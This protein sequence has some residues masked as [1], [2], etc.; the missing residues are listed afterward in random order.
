MEEPFVWV[1]L[2]TLGL[3]TSQ[4][5]TEFPAQITFNLGD[6]VIKES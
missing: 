2:S 4:G 6:K 1:F 3:F 5:Q